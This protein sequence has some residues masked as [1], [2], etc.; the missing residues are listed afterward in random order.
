MV[1]KD[2]THMVFL[3]N[4]YITNLGGRSW[5]RHFSPKT[6]VYELDSMQ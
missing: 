6:S 5:T 2:T 4:S 1:L 3:K